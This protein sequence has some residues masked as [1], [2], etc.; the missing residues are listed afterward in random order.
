MVIGAVAQVLEDV[1]GLGEVGLADPVR[2]FPAHLGRGFEVELGC[3][4]AIQW[5]PMPPI[6]RLS[7][8]RGI[9]EECG[10]PEQK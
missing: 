9:D 1:V 8:G 6:S 3:H 2:P 10:Q 5:Q 7:I 4:T